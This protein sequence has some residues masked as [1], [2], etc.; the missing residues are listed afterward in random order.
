MMPSG[1]SS[2]LLGKAGGVMEDVSVP[3]RLMT[4]EGIDMPSAYPGDPKGA[5]AR[6]FFL[7]TRSIAGEAQAHPDFVRAYHVH[8]VIESIYRSGGSAGWVRPADL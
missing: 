8:T 5:M 4:T 3:A 6:S 7:M 2:V 1:E